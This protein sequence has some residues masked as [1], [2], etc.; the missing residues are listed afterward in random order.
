MAK[1]PY[2]IKTLLLFALT[3]FI[4]YSPFSLQSSHIG[5]PAFPWTY[6]ASFQLR[7]FELALPYIKDILLRYLQ[8][9]LLSSF[10][11]NVTIS[12]VRSTLIS[13]SFWHFYS[14]SVLFFSI[15]DYY[16]MINFF[17]FVYT[18]KCSVLYA[19]FHL[20]SRPCV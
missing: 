18:L 5:L 15:E 7:L 4:C 8:G 2:A 11:A 12:E 9:S 3:A 10:R 13:L 17:W 16:Y 1:K 20:S 6:Q 19:P 14:T